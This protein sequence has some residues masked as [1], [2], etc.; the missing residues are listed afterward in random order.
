MLL[1]IKKIVSAPT[2]GFTLIELLLGVA[3]L[4]AVLG[5]V[6]IMIREVSQSQMRTQAQESA[7]ENIQQISRVLENELRSAES[8]T[9]LDPQTLQYTTPAGTG[10]FTL[11]AEQLMVQ[12]PSMSQGIFVHSDNIALKNALWSI[13]EA[14]EG[15]EVLFTADVSSELETRQKYFFHKQIQVKKPNVASKIILF[16]SSGMLMRQQ[17]KSIENLQIINIGDASVVI[18]QLEVSWQGSFGNTGATFNSINFA[19]GANEWTGAVSSGNIIDHSDFVLAAGLQE[20]FDFT[21]SESVVQV[22]L[23]LKFYFSDQTSLPIRL[24]L[25]GANAP[26]PTPTPTPTGSPTPTPTGSPTPTPPPPTPP[27]SCTSICAGQG[28]SSGSCIGNAN[29]CKSPKVYQPSGNM[30]CTGGANADTCC[31]TP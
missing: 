1:S 27:P 16:D 13:R 6:S 14:N 15:Q 2:Q 10:T 29:Q 9:L 17:D 25:I 12:G 23:I 18:T 19:G 22:E 11:S 7:F 26:P 3:L 8:V 31:C 20:S 30:Y 4:S 28:Y 21:F 5:S 24:T